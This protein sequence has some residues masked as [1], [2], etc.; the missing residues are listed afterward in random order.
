MSVVR[1]GEYTSCVLRHS[2]LSQRERTAYD[3]KEGET[4]YTANV[5]GDCMLPTIPA[6]ISCKVKKKKEDLVCFS[7]LFSN[8]LTI[9]RAFQATSNPVKFIC[10]LWGTP[11]NTG[12]SYTF[13]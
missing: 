10:M 2:I 1:G 4:T 7:N 12:I 8:F 11:C 3:V 13:L 5:Y 6:K 9:L